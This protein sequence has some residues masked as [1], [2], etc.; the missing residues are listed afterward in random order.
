M[1]KKKLNPFA[2]LLFSNWLFVVIAL[3]MV[4]VQYST[5]FLW[6]GVIFEASTL[7]ES[8]KF[9]TCVAL[10]ATVLASAALI[11]Y[12]PESYAKKLPILDEDNSLGSSS[13]L[14][15]AYDKQANAKVVTKKTANSNR[16]DND[17][18]YQSLE[19]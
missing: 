10:G 14:M 3:G 4:A 6:I 18:S 9:S 17:D 11:K 12:V 13:K 1:N 19:M 2:D 16:V 5:C 7:D 8:V 15:Q